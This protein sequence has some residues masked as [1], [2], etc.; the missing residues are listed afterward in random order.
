MIGH[1]LAGRYEIISRIGGGGMALVYKA[2]DVLLNRKVAVKVLRQQFVNDEEFISRFRREAQNAAA[3][4]HPNVVSIYD[5]GQEEDIHYIVME[6]VE[7]HNLNEIIVERAPLQ[8]EEAVHVAQQICDA[9]DHAHANHI[10][11]RD[12]KPHNILIGNNGRVKVTDFGIARAAT[13][14]KITH[15]GSVVGSVHYFSPEHA[16]GVNTGEKSDLYSLGIVLYQMVTGNLPFFGESPISIALKHLQDD[17]EEPRVVNSHIPQS[18]ENIIL[19]S[20]RKN[21]N[22]RYESARAMMSDLETCLQPHRLYEPKITF[23]EDVDLQETKVMPAIRSSALHTDMN[24]GTV[25]STASARLSDTGSVMMHTGRLTEEE[26]EKAAGGWKKP[27]YVVLIT[28]VF[29]AALLWGFF[30]LLDTFK[31]EDV[32]IPYVVDL[33]EEEARKKLAEAGLNVTEPV[34]RETSKHV[35]KDKVIAQSKMNMKVKEGSFIE[36]TISAGPELKELPSYIGSM[37]QQTINALIDLGIQEDQLNFTEV[38]DEAPAGTILQQTPPAGEEIN[39]DDVQISFTVSKGLETVDMPDLTDARLKDAK[40]LLQSL[41]LVL[42]EQDITYEPSYLYAKDHIIS[43]GNAQPNEKIEKGSK[44]TV[45]VSSGYPSDAKSYQFNVKISPAIIGTASEVRI[46]YS[47]A[48]GEN[49]ELESRTITSTV[50]IPVMLVLD[51][52]TEA[53]VSVHRDGTFMDI[54]SIKYRDIAQG[55]HEMII[56]GQE[57]DPTPPPTPEHEF[58]HGGEHD[59][60]MEAFNNDEQSDQ[61]ANK[62]EE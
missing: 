22:E 11:H 58:F 14:S 18:V 7:G 16:K 53:K 19:K 52:E 15:T 21:P 20:M 6:Y 33:T 37:K 32:D 29:L 26:S 62:T 50:D 13:S 55:P 25:N 61:P 34:T 17:F 45:K 51:P 49:M 47:D 23:T 39:P 35:P 57:P 3:L 42:E 12:I 60:D 54:V 24:T 1:D 38:F 2:H 4:S 8:I 44:V 28:L 30:K 10:I 40:V 46:Y 27:L 9:L 43:Q 41:G 5:V 59:N 56:P 31:T 48:R 36:L